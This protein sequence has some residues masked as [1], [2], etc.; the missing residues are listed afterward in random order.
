MLTGKTVLIA[1]DDRQLLLAIAMKCRKLG[2]E[3][4]TVSNGLDVFI[5]A[6][7][8]PPDLFIL[9]INM[10][11]GDGLRVCQK[12]V[13]YP[14]FR[15]IP[16]IFLTGRFDQEA[17]GIVRSWGHGTCSRITD[18]GTRSRPS[19]PNC[20]RQSP[21][22]ARWPPEARAPRPERASV[23]GMGGRERRR[24]RR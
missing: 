10:P 21:R 6:L 8:A 1:D 18:P 7:A 20:F 12:L 5:Q 19:L 14:G 15:A 23:P 16:I 4:R 22:H 2:F 11:V 13:H 3:V 9:D 24:T 17:L